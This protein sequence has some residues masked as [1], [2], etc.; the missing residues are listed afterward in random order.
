MADKK[1]LTSGNQL[2]KLKSQHSASKVSLECICYAEAPTDTAALALHQ[3]LPDCLTNLSYITTLHS[4]SKI[5]N[6][7][8]FIRSRLTPC[9]VSLEC[10]CHAEAPTD[11]AALALYH[12]LLEKPTIL[13][14]FSAL[15]LL[16][17]TLDTFIWNHLTLC[18]VSTDAILLKDPDQRAAN[19]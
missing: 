16:P 10:I 12:L 1:L 5:H 3:L 15:H 6:L 19:T 14:L 9:E 7:D 13:N 18:E 8:T 4:Q 11:T 2:Y 17:Y